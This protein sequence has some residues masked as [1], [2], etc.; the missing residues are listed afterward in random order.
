[1][2]IINDKVRVL[3]FEKGALDK[4]GKLFRAGTGHTAIQIGDDVFSKELL[5]GFTQYTFDDYAKKQK[6]NRDGE[7]FIINL[8]R[9]DNG[10]LRQQILDNRKLWLPWN[11]CNSRAVDVLNKYCNTLMYDSADPQTILDELL[12]AEIA[13]SGFTVFCKDMINY[14]QDK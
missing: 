1:M 7:V 3:V 13:E 6:D 11:T 2:E 5:P 4:V 9:T 14:P 8:N 12:K 10:E